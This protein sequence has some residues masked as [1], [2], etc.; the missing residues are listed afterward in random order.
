[1]KR[2]IAMIS[3][4]KS[5]FFVTMLIAQIGNAQ[6]CNRNIRIEL[7]N[8]T[9]LN[10]SEIT[11]SILDKVE[12]LTLGSCNSA[13]VKN[14]SLD[15]K[16]FVGLS[17]LKELTLCQEIQFKGKIFEPLEN[18]ETLSILLSPRGFPYDNPDIEMFRGLKN[19][20]NLVLEVGWFPKLPLLFQPLQDSLTSLRLSVKYPPGVWETADDTGYF[21]YLKNLKSLT[22]SDG[23]PYH[24]DD[25]NL[26]R[27]NPAFNFFAGLENLE[28]LFIRS[29]RRFAPDLFE[30]IKSLK[31]LEAKALKVNINS[32]DSMP[33]LEVLK[34]DFAYPIHWPNQGKFKN[35]NHLKVL[36][37][38]SPR[39][40]VPAPFGKN[41][42]PENFQ[43]FMEYVK[44]QGETYFVNQVP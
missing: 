44:F 18:L 15:G 43:N 35:L 4:R 22:F 5:L 3:K 6:V 26:S 31:S 27:K 9:G 40:P 28:V 41:D 42:L 25:Y 16:D 8:L 29:I 1:M 34:L 12:K 38:S 20:K 10:C 23:L 19:L 21:V 14:I 11:P 39:N 33:N 7:Q 17:K 32:F 2:M 30:D 37:I 13:P 24:P 36:D